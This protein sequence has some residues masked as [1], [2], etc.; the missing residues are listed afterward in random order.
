MGI[1]NS[2]AFLSSKSTLIHESA[3]VTINECKLSHSSSRPTLSLLAPARKT[4]LFHSRDNQ[5]VGALR[6]TA[7]QNFKLFSLRLIVR[8]EEPLNLM[9]Q[10]AV[11]T[12]LVTFPLT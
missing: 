12:R 3:G 7:I 6:T 8:D 5:V 1:R 10:V 11:Q 2:T 9:Q 4:K